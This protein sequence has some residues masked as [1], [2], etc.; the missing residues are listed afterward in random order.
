M[1][2]ADTDRLS[3]EYAAGEAR[4]GRLGRALRVDLQVWRELASEILGDLDDRIFG[5]GWWAPYPGTSRRILISDHLFTCARSVETNLVEARLHLMEAMDFWERESDFHARTVRLT[6]DGKMDVE[7]PERKRPIDDVQL[8][9]ATLHTVGFVRAIAGAVDCFGAVIV[10]VTALKVKLLRADLDNARRSL[11]RI[12]GATAGE[13]AQREF[14]ERLEAAIERSGPPG[15]LRWAIDLRNMLIHRG[16]RL[17]MSELRPV[18]SGI[19]GLD[20]KPVIRTDVI[21]QLPRDP[22]RSDVEMFLD[23]SRPPVLTESA[24]MTLLGVRESTLRLF[25][26]GATLLRDLWRARRADPALLI[27]PREQW[28]DSSSWAT[29]GFPGYAP[30]SVPYNPTQLRSDEVLLRRMSAASLGDAER[31]A[32]ARFD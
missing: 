7:L 12:A 4:E 8:A 13:R 20:G 31:G 25:G 5:V 14:S 15:W 21:R 9:M 2:S 6:R 22:G 18:P 24:A 23:T 1:T 27:Q 17:E 16:R 28:P 10:G 30:D 19:V 11:D 32:W 3:R 26:D 29:T